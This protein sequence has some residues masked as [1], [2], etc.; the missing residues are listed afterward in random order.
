MAKWR[1]GFEHFLSMWNTKIL[2][3]ESVEDTAIDDHTKRIWLTATLQSNS[4]M[5]AAICQAQTTQLTMT[6]M[7]STD[8][9]PSWSSFYSMLLYIAKVLDKEKSEVSKTQRRVHQTE[10]T[11][12]PGRSTQ[13]GGRS[14]NTRP[15]RGPGQRNQGNHP[16]RQFTK[17]L[18]ASMTMQTDYIFSRALIGPN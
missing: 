11:R 10:T 14:S 1:S 4:E 5:R 12:N 3:L 6:G 13:R 8:T 16:P 9:P 7:S 17:Y 18:G 2:D 15:G